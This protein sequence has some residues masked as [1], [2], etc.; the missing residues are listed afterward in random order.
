MKRLA[1]VAVLLAFVGWRE[2][3]DQIK[4][5]DPPQATS[6]TL[7]DEC[8]QDFAKRIKS[9][10]RE[11]ARKI[12]AGEF[13]TTSDIEAWAAA[14][15]LKCDREAFKPIDDAEANATFDTDWRASFASKWKEWGGDE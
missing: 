5:P 11:G 10:Y 6:Q 7:A 8:C 2:Y 4:W 15:W 13:K 12:E 9:F 14:N 3:G 1:I